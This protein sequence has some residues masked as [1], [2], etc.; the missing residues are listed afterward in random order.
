MVDVGFLFSRAFAG[1]IVVYR[2]YCLSV[3]IVK[4]GRKAWRELSWRVFK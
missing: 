3:F 1:L 4:L 2:L